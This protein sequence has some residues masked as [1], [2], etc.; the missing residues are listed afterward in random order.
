MC[1]SSRNVNIPNPKPPICVASNMCASSRNVNI[2]KPPISVASN[3]CASSRNVNIPKKPICV[4][5][6]MF[7]SSRNVNIPKKPICVASTMRASS[8]MTL[9]PTPPPQPLLRS[10]NHACKFK[11]DIAPHP[12]TPTPVQGWRCHEKRGK[13][14][15]R[16]STR[17]HKHQVSFNGRSGSKCDF[18]IEVC[19]P[20]HES[21]YHG[22]MI[23]H[24]PS[25]QPKG[26][27]DNKQKWVDNETRQH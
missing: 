18:S 9:H 20:L 24:H 26:W 22:R 6:N 14:A 10:I 4:A 27:H 5:S 7:A 23:G 25:Q 12:P 15:G 13:S 16:F 11:D 8:R 1:A 19:H 3:M 21:L 2:P 17:R